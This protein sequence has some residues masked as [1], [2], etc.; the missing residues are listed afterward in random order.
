[1]APRLAVGAVF[2]PT[3]LALG[4]E[5]AGHIVRPVDAEADPGAIAQVDLVLLDAPQLHLPEPTPAAT[6]ATLS[7]PPPSWIN[8]DRARAAYGS[9]R[10][11]EV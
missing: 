10:G 3:P 7:V 5:R 9:F 2:G 1:M 6:E 11:V 4:F 8:A